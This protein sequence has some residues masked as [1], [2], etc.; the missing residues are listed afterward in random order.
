VLAR[1]RISVPD[2]PGSLG[3]V[4]SAIGGAGADIVQLGVLES[5]SGRALDDVFVTVRDPAHLS[6]VRDR[7]ESLPGVSV[8]GVQHPAPPTTGHADL[9]LLDQ[10][11]SRPDR[12]LQTLVD[13]APHAF[14]GDWCAL[15]EYGGD[16]A[17]SGV[18]ATSVGCPGADHVVVRSPLRLAPI[19]MTPPNR[20]TPYGGTALVPIGA[21]STGLVIVRADG[22]E[23]HR[24]ELW[25]LGQVGQIIGT[26][27]TPVSHG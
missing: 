20:S 23:F 26:V 9:E 12:G 19:R 15:V 8:I 1:V 17:M 3:T 11:L 6:A 14:G 21:G 25:R 10:V 5:E 18:V 2:R 24:S 22:P 4:T 16:G 13:G 7:L 27:L